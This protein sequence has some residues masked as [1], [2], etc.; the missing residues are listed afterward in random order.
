MS[1]FQNFLPYLNL[2][3]VVA[4]SIGGIMAM[5]AGYFQQ[6]GAAQE[7][8]ITALQATT[9]TQEKQIIRLKQENVA[10][11][12]AFKQLGMEIE[13]DGDIVTLIDAQVP[14]KKRIMQIHMEQDESMKEE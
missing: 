9:D 8:A 2:V 13:F 6:S 11:R 14:R 10:M 3:L 5:R 12:M 1:M 4:L 7:R